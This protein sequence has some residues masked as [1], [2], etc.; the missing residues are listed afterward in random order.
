M[1]N[2]SNPHVF[3][4]VFCRKKKTLIDIASAEYEATF[5]KNVTD[6]KN[7][8]CDLCHSELDLR[9]TEHPRYRVKAYFAHKRNTSTCAGSTG[10]SFKHL[11]A[12]FLLKR[13]F[14][15][16]D[17]CLEACTVCG[18]WHGFEPQATDEVL[19]EVRKKISDNKTYIYDLCVVRNLGKRRGKQNV[20][21]IE[22]F[23]THKTEE[24]KIY[25]TKEIGLE[26]AEVEANTII[27]MQYQLEHA[28]KNSYCVTIPNLLTYYDVCK[29]CK[30]KQKKEE[31]QKQFDQEF[32][33]DCFPESTWRLQMQDEYQEFNYEKIET[34]QREKILANQK[35]QKNVQRPS[36]KIKFS[37]E[38]RKCTLCQ[39]WLPQDALKRVSRYHWKFFEFK[40]MHPWHI[41]NNLKLPCFAL[42]CS[43]CCI[44]CQMCNDQV[45]IPLAYARRHGVCCWCL[46]KLQKEKSYC[47][48]AEKK[49]AFY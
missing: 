48:M 46:D 25:D 11:Q 23:N 49:S 22:V 44:T 30:R 3:A 17:I 2:S 21:A 1:S 39:I 42:I 7:Y 8:T 14:G 27:S 31:E 18:P 13:F 38:N 40:K 4:R 32:V 5:P 12:K 28:Q 41:E 9:R 16:Y 15:A 33:F 19:F 29:K 35:Y 24:K 26:I 6:L 47:I 10:E 20:L 45:H 36:K 34:Q 43:D 37:K